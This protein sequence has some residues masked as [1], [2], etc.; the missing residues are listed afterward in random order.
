MTRRLRI[1]AA[2]LS[3]AGVARWPAML[4]HAAHH[5]LWTTGWV[6]VVTAAISLALAFG[7]HPLS[8]GAWLPRPVLQVVPAALIGMIPN[9]AVSVAIVELH[10]P[11]QLAFGATIAGLSAGAGFGPIV[12]PKDGSRRDALR[13]LGLTLGAAIVT[14]ALV[15][16]MS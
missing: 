10:L 13:V 1:L 7:S 5:T 15:Q 3:I 9:C 2:F 6:F 4:R 8:A 12:L 11:G 14:G 16:W